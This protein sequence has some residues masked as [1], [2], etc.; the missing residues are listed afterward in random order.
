MAIMDPVSDM[1]TRI[2]NAIGANHDEVNVPFSVF[3]L[4]IA[5]ILKE[6]G[7]IKYYEIVSEDLKKK[8]LKIGLKYAPDGS[9]IISNLKNVS[10][11]GK[12]QYLQKS[13]IPKIMS[14]FGICIVSTSKGVMSGRNARLKRVGGELVGIIH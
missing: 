1:F 11:P 10:R 6:E 13:E 5:K 2:R 7:F 12:R 3:K 9:S 8:V 14:G 4:G